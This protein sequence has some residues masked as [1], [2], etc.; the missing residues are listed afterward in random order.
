[1]HYLER[2]DA[3]AQ[4]V[5]LCIQTG[6]NVEDENRLKFEG[7]EF[8][9]KDTQ[10]MKESFGALP[11]EALKNTLKIADEIELEFSFDKM[12]CAYD[13]PASYEDAA[14]F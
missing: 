5:L 2:E 11:A 13:I 12:Y 6:K 4:D 7:D 14:D 9:F 3:A 10:E 8:Y 1:M